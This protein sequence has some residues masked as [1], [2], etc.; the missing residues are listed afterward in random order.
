MREAFP[1]LA[2]RVK[3]SRTTINNVLKK[4]RLNGY[5]REQKTWKFFRAK[6]QNELWQ[7]DLKGGFILHG[8][9]H[10]FLVVIDD[11]SRYL[12]L[13]HH[14][15]H[16]PTTQEIFDLLLPLIERHRPKS[17]LSDNGSQFRKTWERLC[18]QYGM[19]PLFAHPYY[20]QDK[21][22]VER[23]IR[24]INQ[25]FI[26]QLKKFPEWISKLDEYVALFNEIRFHRGINTM[27]AA[28]F[29]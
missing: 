8:K 1:E 23:A 14:F 29:T 3:L 22:K 18:K 17:I 4:H 13:T 2:Q 5:K 27:P 10:W 6:R 24:N 19:K 11:Y 28:L 20:P 16:V 7:I 25:E 21:G 15:D 26:Y 12:L 9:K